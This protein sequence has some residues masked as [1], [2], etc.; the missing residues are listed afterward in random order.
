MRTN[1]FQTIDVKTIPV[2]GITFTLTATEEECRALAE[3]FDLPAVYSFELSGTVKG[4]DILRYDGR[5]E[6]KVVRECVVSLEE[7]EQTVL[8]E[9]SELFSESGTDFS[10]ETN[11]DIDM[12]DEE[13]VDLIKNGRLEIGEIAAQQFALNLDPFPKKEEGVFEYTEAVMD[14]TNPFE[15][16]KNLKK[17]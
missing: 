11:F 8:G 13:T 16:L 6:A 17:K 10:V 5:F 14:K 2:N 1:L 4:N 15:I 7:F 12:D 9:F 3:R